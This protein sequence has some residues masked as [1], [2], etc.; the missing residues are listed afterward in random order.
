MMVEMLNQVTNLTHELENCGYHPIQIKAII[1]EAI[2]QPPDNASRE[3]LAQLISEL[4]SYIQFA[5]K[6]KACR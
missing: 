5:R 1:R 6:C 4:E 2:D 3:D